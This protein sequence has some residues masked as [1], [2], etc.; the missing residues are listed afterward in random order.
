M[1][2]REAITAALGIVPGSTLLKVFDENIE[3]LE[4]QEG[5]AI[6]AIRF[7]GKTFALGFRLIP[8]KPYENSKGITELA[9]ILERQGHTLA[10][11]I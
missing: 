8:G 3:K 6:A 9:R 7:N 1:D 5:T 11:F 2:R 4:L 10:P